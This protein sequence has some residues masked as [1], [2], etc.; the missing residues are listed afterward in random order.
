MSVAYDQIVASLHDAVLVLNPECYIIGLNPAAEYLLGIERTQV[1]YLRLSSVLTLP[2]ETP[3]KAE[4]QT[5]F[6]HAIGQRAYEVTSLPLVGN[7]AV[8]GRVL[9]LR[10]ITA[11][12]R[13]ERESQQLAFER[14]RAHIMTL[15]IRDA[16]HE[17]RTPIT[18]IKM[19]AYLLATQTIP[20]KRAKQ[21]STIW[22][23]LE[24]LSHLIEDLQKM[25]ILDNTPELDLTTADLHPFLS[26][27]WEKATAVSN[28]RDIRLS[29][30]DSPLFCAFD[31]HQLDHALMRVLDNAV[32]YSSGGGLI[33][34]TTRRDVHHAYIDIHDH[35]I[36]MDAD[37]LRQATQRFYRNDSAHSTAGFGLGL[38]IAKTIIELHGGKLSLESAIGQ[39]TTVTLQLPV[40]TR[41]EPITL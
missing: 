5:K 34:L 18:V 11:R 29:V 38:P 14:K 39:G 7:R 8:I 20:H 15:F 41:P 25:A 21:I 19:T 10:D 37:T 9:V 1:M 23:Q 13:A 4:A 40:L 16:S 28:G 12:K 24:R 2:S 32:R 17:F 22:T 27:V 26:T 36:G 6:E 35:G 31:A 3:L 33:Q 30:D